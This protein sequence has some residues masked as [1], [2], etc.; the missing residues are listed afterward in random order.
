M[1]LYKMF[2]PKDVKAGVNSAGGNAQESKVSAESPDNGDASP[3]VIEVYLKKLTNKV[4]LQ[5]AETQ[6]TLM[7]GQVDDRIEKLVRV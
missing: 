2:S 4:E 6:Y 3:T 5:L 7:S 1:L